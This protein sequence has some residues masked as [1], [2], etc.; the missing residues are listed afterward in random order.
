MARAPQYAPDAV[1]M[2]AVI[3]LVGP[4]PLRGLYAAW[5]LLPVLA[6]YRSFTRLFY[7]HSGLLSSPNRTILAMGER[8]SRRYSP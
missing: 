7:S 8:C 1:I 3:G 6:T 2:R 5:V 4:D